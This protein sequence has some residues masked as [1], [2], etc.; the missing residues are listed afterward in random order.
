MPGDD[1]ND[2]GTGSPEGASG[3]EPLS[4]PGGSTEALRSALADLQDRLRLAVTQPIP[5][6]E[7]TP[8]AGSAMRRALKRRQVRLMR[9]VSRRYDRL[10]ADLAGLAAGLAERLSAAEA[11]VI[12]LQRAVAGLRDAPGAP[13][14]LPDPATDVSGAEADAYYWAF[15][16]AMRGSQGSIE[17]RLRQYEPRLVELRA[18]SSVSTPRWLDLGCGRGEFC[19]IVREWG[20][21]VHGVDSSPEAVEACRQAGIDASLADALE[22]LGDY[23]GPAPLGISAIQVIEHLPKELWLAFFRRAYKALGSGGAL[24]VETINP[25]NFEALSASF[26]ADVTHTW[27]AHPEVARL[28]ALHTGFDRAEIQFVNEDERGNAQDFALWATR[29]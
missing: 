1:A 12:R 25:L 6:G 7:V 19:R 27:P 29:E 23:G 26:F 5:D 15:E 4:A 11:D 28:M 8:S 18:S 3:H 20:Y 21:E 14:A 17:S 13:H 24:L 9:P 2:Q 22:F 10:A 16:Q